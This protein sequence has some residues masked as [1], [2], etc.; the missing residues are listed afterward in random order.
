MQEIN[1]NDFNIYKTKLSELESLAQE[2]R[3]KIQEEEKIIDE[4]R[5]LKESMKEFMG[6]F[7]SEQLSKYW[8]N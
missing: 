5:E 2:Y 4:L 7:Y 8:R 6:S 3:E 1:N